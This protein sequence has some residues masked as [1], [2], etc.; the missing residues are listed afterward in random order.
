MI[1]EILATILTIAGF[2]LVAEKNKT[3]FYYG[4]CGN[5]LWIYWGI[6]FATG[7]F[8]FLQFCLMIIN[9]AGIKKY[10]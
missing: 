6:G 5:I 4:L 10:D 2:Y 8:Y 7:A 1:I 3:G 9:I